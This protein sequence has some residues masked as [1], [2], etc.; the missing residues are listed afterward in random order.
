VAISATDIIFNVGVPTEKRGFTTLRT[1]RRKKTRFSTTLRKLYD[2]FA[3]RVHFLERIAVTIKT[4][5]IMNK[6]VFFFI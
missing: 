5:R 4:K 6:P 2:T 1:R 3:V